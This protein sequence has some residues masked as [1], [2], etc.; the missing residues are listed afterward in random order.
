MTAVLSEFRFITGPANL[1]DVEQL[2]EA[3]PPMDDCRLAMAAP[4]APAFARAY[5]EGVECEEKILA[6]LPNMDVDRREK[7]ERLI[8]RQTHNF[9]GSDRHRMVSQHTDYSPTLSLIS[10]KDDEVD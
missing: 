2:I 6:D 9:P 1:F 3:V 7:F 4:E 5:T 10:D 8:F